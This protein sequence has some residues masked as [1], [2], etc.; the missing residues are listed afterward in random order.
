VSDDELP[1]LEELFSWSGQILMKYHD[2]VIRGGSDYPPGFLKAFA[3]YADKEFIFCRECGNG[4]KSGETTLK[5]TQP[6]ASSRM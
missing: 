1:W 2:A 3:R 5:T 6:S 4:F